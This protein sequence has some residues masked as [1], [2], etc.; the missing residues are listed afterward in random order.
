LLI[1][2]L[3]LVVVKRGLPL[4]VVLEDYE[5]RLLQQ[6]VVGRLNRQCLFLLGQTIQ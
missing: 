4:V 3:S 2:L 5:V 6:V 1:I